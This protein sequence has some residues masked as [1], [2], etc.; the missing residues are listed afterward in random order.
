[1]RIQDSLSLESLALGGHPPPLG[2]TDSG[3]KVGLT[4]K[5]SLHAMRGLGPLRISLPIKFFPKPPWEYSHGVTVY[6]RGSEKRK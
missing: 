5:H 3:K 6:T 4:P 1:M 2:S